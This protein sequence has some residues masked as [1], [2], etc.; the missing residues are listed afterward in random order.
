MQN[1]A[2]NNR[3]A[4]RGSDLDALMQEFDQEYS[5]MLGEYHAGSEYDDASDSFLPVQQ[6]AAPVQPVPQ[7]PVQ[8]PAYQQP[9]QNQAYQ[10]PMQNQV[11]QQPVQ[12]PAYQ[13]TQNQTYR[14]PP[15]RMNQRPGR[16]TIPNTNGYAFSFGEG[17]TQQQ[18]AATAPQ[19]AVQTRPAAQQP[20]MPARTPSA[21]KEK[22]AAPSKAKLIRDSIMVAGMMLLF[23][24]CSMVMLS[25]GIKKVEAPADQKSFFEDLDAEM[26]TF[27]SDSLSSIFSIPKV[28]ILPWGEQPAPVANPAGFG[29]EIAE[30]GTKVLTY[31]DDTISVR[32]WMERI[33]R[34]N[35]HFAEIKVAHHTQL[36]TAYAGGEFGSSQKYMPKVIAQ[37][38]NA[39]IAINGDYCGY[40]T[41][42]ILVRQ[43]TL[44]R[45]TARGWDTLLIDSKGDFHIMKDRD[46]HSSGIMDEYEI[47]NTLVFGPSLV[48]DGE[49]NILNL[50]SGCGDIWNMKYSPR[51]AVGQLG[52]LHYLFC[53]VEGRSDDSVGVK[54]PR[55]AEIMHEKGCVQAY[56]LDG[57][58]ST[59]M[60]FNGEAM[61][62]PLWGSQRV[63]TD[64]LYCATAIP[65]EGGTASE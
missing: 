58:Q 3:Q 46:I 30:D 53:C 51:T 55:L 29:E 10:Q 11:Y 34:S 43:N 42:G 65:N 28:Y 15:V 36:R 14:Q 21:A 2:N 50:D 38:V 63:V 8:N 26:L 4:F 7:Q 1:N 41:G 20:Q 9:M 31:N 22:K 19:P 57:G 24:L 17:N 39:V 62:E 54:T 60:I 16:R 5:D 13:Q 52:T 25:S 33:S 32:Y 23:T 18:Y 37:Q 35:V 56:N 59:T 6:P 12:N 40:R 45:N 64:I 61:N 49:V 47:V 48:V 27:K 44:Y